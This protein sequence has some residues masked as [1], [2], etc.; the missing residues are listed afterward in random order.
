MRL[1]VQHMDELGPRD[2][3]DPGVV[4]D[5]ELVTTDLV[6]INLGIRILLGS[7]Y[8]DDWQGEEMFVPKDPLGN[9]VDRRHPWNQTTIPKPQ[10]RDLEGGNYCWVMS[11][12]WHDKR[13]GEHLALDTG[14]GAFARLWATALAGQGRQAV[15]QGARPAACR[16]TCRRRRTR[17]RQ[18][19]KWRIPQWSNAIERNRARIYFVAYAA[20]M[21]F[22]FVDRALTEVRSGQHEGRSRTSR[23][24]TRRSAAASTRRCAACCRTTSSS[25]TGRSPTTTPT[26]RRRGTDPDGLER[27]PGP[28]EDAV[29]D[30]PIFEENDQDNFRGIDIMRAVRELRPV[31]AVRRAH[32]PRQGQDAEADAHPDV[33]RAARLGGT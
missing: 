33:R 25:A 15:R 22:R 6:D 1:Q 12:R 14:G 24:R 4:V 19:L 20:A 9:A 18:T 5:G 16:S 23:C 26:R 2:E 32:V 29:P 11:P 21:A 17:P 10:K 13:T 7:S 8:Y 28:Y 3:G 30:M 31:P 27:T